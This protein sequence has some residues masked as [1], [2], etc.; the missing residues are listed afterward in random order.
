[1]ICRPAFYFVGVKNTWLIGYF[2]L[3]LFTFGFKMTLLGLAHVQCMSTRTVR[4]PSFIRTN[5]FLVVGASEVQVWSVVVTCEMCDC[6]PSQTDL[7][8]VVNNEVSCKH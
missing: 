3:F 5:D 6:Q 4:T 1:M 8:T 7:Y 2:H